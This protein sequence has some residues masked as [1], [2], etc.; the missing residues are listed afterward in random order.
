M[1]VGTTHSIQQRLPLEWGPTDV[2]FAF[3]AFSDVEARDPVTPVF[4]VP[5]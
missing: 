5:L 2:S 3:A 1:A 4:A